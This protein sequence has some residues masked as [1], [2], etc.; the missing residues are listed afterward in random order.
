[1]IRP[2]S[3]A[4]IWWARRARRDLYQIGDFIARDKPEAAARWVNRIQ[5]AVERVAG[6][7]RSGRL[8]PEIERDDIREVILENYRIVYQI[9][10]DGIIILTVF[11]SHMRLSERAIPASPGTA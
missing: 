4:P 7:P 1:M 9:R 2:R 6:F 10:D 5:D 8:V 3:G 11:E